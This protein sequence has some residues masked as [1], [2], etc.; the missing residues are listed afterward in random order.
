M[1][2]L[3]HL[4]IAAALTLAAC[5]SDEATPATAS[6]TQIIAYDLVSVDADGTVTLKLTPTGEAAGCRLPN[7]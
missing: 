3:A 7:P 6:E 5:G 4:A 1:K 2:K